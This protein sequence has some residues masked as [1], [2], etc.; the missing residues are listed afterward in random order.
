MQALQMFV[1]PKQFAA[2]DGDDFVHAITKNKT[3][4]QHWHTSLVSGQ[5]F[6]VEVDDV[7]GGRV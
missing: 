5:E 1:E 7:H 2:V 3:A 4:I 6:I